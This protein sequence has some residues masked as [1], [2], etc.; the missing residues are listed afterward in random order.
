MGQKPEAGADP[1]VFDLMGVGGG[2]GGSSFGSER[3]VEIFC[4]KLLPPPP[5]H[6]LPP[7]AVACY[8]FNDCFI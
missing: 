6:P 3:T 2:G 5:P 7:V 1:G 8:N 4:G